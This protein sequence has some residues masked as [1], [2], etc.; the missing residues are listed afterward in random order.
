M[1]DLNDANTDAAIEPVIHIAY[2]AVCFTGLR[3]E[4]PADSPPNLLDNNMIFAECTTNDTVI[5]E[6]TMIKEAKSTW[7][8]LTQHIQISTE[9]P[10]FMLSILSRHPEHDDYIVAQV[11]FQTASVISE[12]VMHDHRGSEVFTHWYSFGSVLELGFRGVVVSSGPSSIPS[13]VDGNSLSDLPTTNGRSGPDL[14]FNFGIDFLVLLSNHGNHLLR[15]STQ[16]GSEDDIQ[17][18]IS[19]LECS[20]SYTLDSDPYKRSR[21]SDLSHAL[22]H[23]FN[24]SGDSRDLDQ[25][26]ELGNRAVTL[27]DG[28]QDDQLSLFSHLS[29]SYLRR[30]N[31]L[32]NLDDLNSAVSAAEFVVSVSAEGSYLKANS[33][34][35]LA[36]CLYQRFE[37]LGELSD[38]ESAIK[39]GRLAFSLTPE[40]DELKCWALQNT[41]LSLSQRFVRLGTSDD[42]EE[43]IS[44]GRKALDF[45]PEDFPEKYSML[46]HL[47]NFL[48]RRF[49]MFGDSADLDEAIVK[50]ID[51]LKAV[52]STS[53]D[54]SGILDTLGSC[55]FVRSQ[56]NGDLNDLTESISLLQSA[57]SNT[58]DG[59]RFKPIILE[60]LSKSF[61]Y[62]FFKTK[63]TDDIDE[64]VSAGRRA[65]AFTPDDDPNK[66]SRLNHLVCSLQDR[67]IHRK[68][69]DDLEES[70]SCAKEALSLIPDGHQEKNHILS[71]LGD[72]VELRFDHFQNRSDADEATSLYK[73]A[74]L[75]PIDRPDDRLYATSRWA[76]LCVKINCPSA[77]E[78][79][80]VALNLL[81]QAVW[82]GKSIAARHR[83]LADYGSIVNE[84]ATYV[85][86][87][88]YTD[89]ALEWLETGRAIVWGQLHNLRSPVDFLS[90]AHPDLMERLSQVTAALEKASSGDVNTEHFKGMT[91]EEIAKEHRRLATEWDGLVER[92]RALPGFEDFLGPKKLASLKNVAKLGPVILVN[93]SPA[94]CDALI[95]RSD[96]DDVLHIPLK[97]FTYEDA[98]NL[99]KQLTKA[100]SAYGVRTRASQP[101]YTTS[102]KSIFMKVLKVLWT[103]IVKP[104]LDGLAFSPCDSTNLPRLWWCPTG[105]LAFL[106]LH[107]A[108]DYNTNKQGT[109]LSDYV[110]SSYIPTLTILL[111][112]LEKIRTF[113]GLLAISQP[114][115]PRMPNLPGT[116]EE[117]QKIKERGTNFFVQYLKGK[118]ATPDT[119]LH[120]MATCNWV[121]MACHATQEKA[122]SLDSTFHLHPSPNYPDGHLP[123]SHLI[124]KSFPDADFA[125]LSACQTATGDESLSEESVHLAAGMLMAGYQSVVAT[126]W[127]IRDSDAP[128]V[129]DEVYSRLFKD[130]KPD[131]RNAAIALHHAVQSLRRDVENESDSLRDREFVRWVPFIHVGV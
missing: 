112:K 29:R 74:A 15:R 119:V 86:Q 85:L 117:L 129:A 60:H 33:L 104:V 108:G 52:P 113:K 107:A 110:V 122:K 94:G 49:Y 23:R 35:H 126:L 37:R 127:S 30:F 75:S 53:P 43:S 114:N 58:P 118:E 88:G 115:T 63:D 109:K 79:Y 40:G 27:A 89:T 42:L 38:I 36:L 19:A 21:L 18:A 95:L 66:P 50:G 106:P 120:G 41:A 128:R 14:S 105:P 98:E 130:G 13:S 100:L 54:R 45:I 39:M 7:W 57:L 93:I 103:S 68:H 64:A 16:F 34:H 31:S 69:I 46:S 10:S 96:L 101:V 80:K 83:R 87:L 1:S 17:H 102:E 28:D 24:F 48:Q 56:L 11:E 4:L 67:F 61:R 55:L 59:H 47:S 90:D 12:F 65:V 99:Q 32:G 125:Y 72:A 124:A 131:S 25:A 91:M 9:I 81:P 20:L 8:E 78:A 5:Q 77:L 97:D 2:S 22:G 44:V 76:S 111:D 62:R 92:V 26:I 123:L 71:H 121:H 51:A 84:A 3:I 73:S 82:T 70:I 6:S 116:E